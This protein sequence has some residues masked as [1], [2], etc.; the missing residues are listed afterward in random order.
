MGG[1][2]AKG[3]SWVLSDRSTT[4]ARVVS[5]HPGLSL[6]SPTSRPSCR[7]RGVVTMFNL[8]NRSFLKEIDFRPDELRFLL[9]LA[10]ALKT[11]KY[12]GV[13]AKRLEGK[14]IALIFE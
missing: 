5:T 14:E 9:Q 7:E 13:E 12:A 4:P 6:L 10:E 3:G 2:P 1:H 11:A 8:R